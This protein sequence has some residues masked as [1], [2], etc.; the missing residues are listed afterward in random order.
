MS[1]RLR[2]LLL[3]LGDA[4]IVEEKTVESGELLRSSESRIPTK[5]GAAGAEITVLAHDGKHAVIV[6]KPSGEG[7]FARRGG[8]NRS[9][10]VEPGDLGGSRAARLDRFAAA[11]TCP[12]P[13]SKASRSSPQAGARATS[14]T[15]IKP[16]RGQSFALEG[17]RRR[18]A[19][20]LD[21]AGARALE[22]A[23]LSGLTAEDVAAAEDIDFSKPSEAI[24]TLTDGNVITDHRRRGRRQALDPG[25][26]DQGR[27][28][29]LP[30]PKAAPSKW[31]SY[32]YDAIFRP[33]RATA[34]AE[35]DPARPLQPKR[36]LR[37]PGR[38][39]AAPTAPRPLRPRDQRHERRLRP[40]PGRSALRRLLLAALLMVY[41]AGRSGVHRTAAR[42]TE[43]TARRWW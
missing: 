8:E 28:A 18:A 6:G 30:R 1:R 2:K 25:E 24:F 31:P 23:A 16:E 42:V 5:P 40:A 19:R 13:R 7:N 32:R 12:R 39:Q 33:A 35:G 14:F 4:K 20:P 26:G 37:R 3:A 38:R 41:T 27:R 15:A 17:R 9:Y 43:E 22:H 36:E 34:G 21:A 11:S 29:R 10:I